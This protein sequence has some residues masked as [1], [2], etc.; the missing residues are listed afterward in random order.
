MQAAGHGFLLVSIW[1]NG[2]ALRPV[3]DCNPWTFTADVSGMSSAQQPCP[4]PWTDGQHRLAILA[5]YS[6]PRVWDAGYHG[7]QPDCVVFTF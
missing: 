7:S 5:P 4:R 6:R 3:L 2:P 1:T